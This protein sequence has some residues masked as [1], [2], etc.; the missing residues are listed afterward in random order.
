MIAPFPV[1]VRVSMPSDSIILS[2]AP[3]PVP[4][5]RQRSEAVSAFAENSPRITTVSGFTVTSPTP[6]TLI[7]LP[8]S[9][10]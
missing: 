7:P 4:V 10:V 6:V 3:P 1:T 5:L 8:L 2:A 9:W